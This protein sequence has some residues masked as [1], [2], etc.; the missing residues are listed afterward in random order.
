MNT[1]TMKKRWKIIGGILGVLLIGG[2]W[3]VNTPVDIKPNY[4]GDKITEEDFAKGNI[5]MNEMQAAYGGK[6]NFL[7]HKTG[8]FVQ[9]AGVPDDTLSTEGEAPIQFQMTSILGTDDSEYTLLNGVDK[10]Q[11]WGMD[12]W[13]SYLLK[14]GQKEFEHHKSY[15]EKMVNS[16]YWFQFPFRIS[17]APIIAYGGE[18]TV[19]GETYDLLYATWGS[20]DVNREYDQYVLYLNQDTKLIEWLNFTYRGKARF[21]HVTAQ[22]VDFKS[23]NGIVAPFSHH[24]TFGSPENEGFSLGSKSYLWIQFGGEKVGR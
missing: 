11:T 14:G 12:N 15:Y 20:E 2:T 5:L 23:I 16:N 10:G 21:V 8:S 3:F 19:K 1:M 7:A 17:E 9:L 6:D 24:T 13:R 18:S 4:L 22:F